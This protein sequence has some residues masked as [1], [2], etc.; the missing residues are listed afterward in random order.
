MTSDGE[1]WSTAQS[2]QRAYEY[3]VEPTVLQGLPGNALL[4][5]PRG[6]ASRDV[7]AVECDPQIIM[8]PGAAAD[9]A[10]AEGAFA[11]QQVVGQGNRPELAAPSQGP[12]WQHC[13]GP[14][15]DS[16]PA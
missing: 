10:A 16:A 2:V 1:S 5:P 12:A 15:A 7:L 11:G 8:L 3:S 6:S 14:A 4:L 9:L 13:R